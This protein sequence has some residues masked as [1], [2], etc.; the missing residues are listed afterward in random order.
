MPDD[1]QHFYD[2]FAAN[3]HLI[4]ADW[5]RSVQRQ[6]EI[7]HRLI[8][9][10]LNTDP[11]NVRLLDCACGIG[12]QALGLA[13]R[14]YRVHATDLSPAAV[15]RAQTEAAHAGVPLTTGVADMRTLSTQ[16]SG[17]FDVVIACDNA[18]P[19]LLT[20]ADLAQ[21]LGEVRAVL[22]LGGLFL[23][24]IRDYDALLAER[25]QFTSERLMDGPAGRRITFQ[26]WDWWPTGEG[27]TVNQFIVIQAGDQWHT[28]HYATD[29]RALRRATLSE[30]L[31]VA[32]FEAIR[33]DLEGYVQP[34]V[35]AHASA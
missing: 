16:V 11:A 32:G 1:V 6:A 4:F 19:H 10:E 7:L 14:G 12:T 18:L 34:L 8:Q 35:L 5:Q 13:Q 25:P 31:A 2:E 29:Y 23:A 24:S 26:V 22:A 3:Y 28:Q 9:T 27:Y 20:D 21:A 15:A 17:P 30:A 33:W